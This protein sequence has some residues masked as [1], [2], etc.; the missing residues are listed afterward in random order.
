MYYYYKLRDNNGHG[1]TYYC[2]ARDINEARDTF[3]L[4]PFY[5]SKATG[6]R[7]SKKKYDAARAGY[8]IHI[9]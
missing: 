7:I 1:D 8:G 5:E 9:R 3:G 6:Y 4:N 2:Q